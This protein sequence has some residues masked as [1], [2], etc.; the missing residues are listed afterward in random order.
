MMMYIVSCII[1]CLIL[2]CLF[3]G[4]GLLIALLVEWLEDRCDLKAARKALKRN[5]FISFDE[6]KR[7]LDL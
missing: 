4:I 7:G 1:S 3:I 2:Y 6:L 5:E